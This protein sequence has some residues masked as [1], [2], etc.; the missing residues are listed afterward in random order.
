VLR[1]GIKT[2]ISFEQ[3]MAEGDAKATAYRQR[4]RLRHIKIQRE[5]DSGKQRRLKQC[6]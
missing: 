1:S 2:M 4:M 5:I 6:G 3:L